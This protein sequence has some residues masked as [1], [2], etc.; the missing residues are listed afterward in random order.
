MVKPPGFFLFFLEGASK[1]V[2][3]YGEA[4]YV[5]KRSEGGLLFAFGGSRSS[6]FA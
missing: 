2:H 3:L 5:G 1:R 6:A 4:A